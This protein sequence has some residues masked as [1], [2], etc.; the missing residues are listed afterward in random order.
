ML[1]PGGGLRGHMAVGPVMQVDAEV[2][3]VVPSLDPA[4][5]T[6]K[7][8]IRPVEAR[9]WLMPGAP[10]DVGFPVRFESAAIERGVIIPRDALVLGAVDTRVIVVVDGHAK[11]ILVDV[12]AT[13]GDRALVS[14]TGLEPG[15]VVVT[16]GNERLRPGQAVRVLDEPATK[17]EPAT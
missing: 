6:L 2:V 1:R 12:L 16:R 4:T 3:G 5:R 10:V 8:R 13:A 9:P 17:Q 7:I 11:P 14:G 15:A